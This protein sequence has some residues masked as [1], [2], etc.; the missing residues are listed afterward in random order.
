VHK[1]RCR[2]L[3][4]LVS[5]LSLFLIMFVVLIKCFTWQDKAYTLWFIL[6]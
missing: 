4:L 2:D 1:C 6:G 3:D 5:I